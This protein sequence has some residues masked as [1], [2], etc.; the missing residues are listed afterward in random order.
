MKSILIIICVI[1]ILTLSTASQTMSASIQNPT[2]SGGPGNEDPDWREG[3]TN[4]IPQ[5]HTGQSFIVKNQTLSSIE[6]A[7]L[8]T[9]NNVAGKD[10]ITMKLLSND[11]RALIKRSRR[12]NVGFDGWLRFDAPGQGLKVTPG[13]K[14]IIR[15]EDTGKVIFGWKYGLDKYPDATAIMFGKEDKK[16]DFLFRVN[17]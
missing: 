12:L 8:T 11:G 4:I 15:L 7:L 9:G 1:V 13:E 5:N 14:L 10:T 16:Y 17:P 3:W 2:D 6:V